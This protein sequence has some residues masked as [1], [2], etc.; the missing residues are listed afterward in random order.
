MCFIRGILHK[1]LIVVVSRGQSTSS[2]L[3]DKTEKGN[4]AVYTIFHLLKV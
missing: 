1:K 3:G 4:F 2:L